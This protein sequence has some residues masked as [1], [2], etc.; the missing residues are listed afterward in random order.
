MTRFHRMV[1]RLLPGPFLGWL[2]T[3]MFLLLMQFLIRYLPD[4]VGK[5][6]PLGVVLELIVYNL[7][8]MVV[9][10]VPMSV[11]IATLMT[12]GRLAETKAYAVI[13]GAGVSFP[14][15]VWPVLVAGLVVAGAMWH[16]NNV[17]LP[18]ANFR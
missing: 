9:L 7:A 15:L 6:L 13:K 3:L 11:L 1:L 17:I 5:G 10:A 12:F 16:F 4:L 18:E 2:A 14:Q 8:Y